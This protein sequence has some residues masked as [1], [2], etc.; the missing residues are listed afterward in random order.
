MYPSIDKIK[1]VLLAGSYISEDD[2][3][4]AEAVAR[5]GASYV[6]YLIRTEL[7]SKPLLGQALAEGHKLAFADLGTHPVSKEHMALIP[8]DA[9]RAGRLVVASVSGDVVVVATDAPEA[10]NT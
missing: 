2:S 8:E 6:E 3:K 4:T 10:V 7:L 9:A 1:A 5:D